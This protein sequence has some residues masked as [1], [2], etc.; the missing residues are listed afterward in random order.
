MHGEVGHQRKAGAF[1]I[2]LRMLGPEDDLFP[3]KRSEVKQI[4]TAAVAYGPRIKGLRPSVHL[5]ASY[6]RRLVDQGGDGS[7]FKDP[8]GPQLGGQLVIFADFPGE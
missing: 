1:D 6:L 4:A 7:R 3:G 8:R 5:A 2:L